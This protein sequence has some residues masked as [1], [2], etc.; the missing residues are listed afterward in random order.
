MIVLQL[1]VDFIVEFRAEWPETGILV[2]SLLHSSCYN[3]CKHE[4]ER[5]AAKRGISTT[6]ATTATTA[7]PTISCSSHGHHTPI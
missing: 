6:T 4:T 3:A 1:L 2:F 5:Y 7:P